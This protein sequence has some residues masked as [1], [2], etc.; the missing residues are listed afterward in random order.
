MDSTKEIVYLGMVTDEDE[1]REY[2]M[3]RNVDDDGWLFWYTKNGGSIMWLDKVEKF[4]S[5]GIY[6]LRLFCYNELQMRVLREF[7]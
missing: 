1:V 6:F 2:F 5:R 4:N 3:E 7:G